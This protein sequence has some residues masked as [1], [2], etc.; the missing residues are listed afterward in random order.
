MRH[1]LLRLVP[2]F[3]WQGVDW[4]AGKVYRLFARLHITVSFAVAM[5]LTLQAAVIGPALAVLLGG[6]GHGIFAPFWVSWAFLVG[7]VGLPIWWFLRGRRIG[8][9]LGLALLATWLVADCLLIVW[10]WGEPLR[11][12][13]VWRHHADLILAWFV[14]WLIPQASLLWLL[15]RSRAET[16]PGGVAGARPPTPD[17]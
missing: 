4:L 5:G 9:F 12:L 3:V 16:R 1:D 17:S 10:T 14:F 7:G 6:A 11:F 2:P 15:I 13:Q 8:I